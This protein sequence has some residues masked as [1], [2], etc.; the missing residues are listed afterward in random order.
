MSKTS[1]DSPTLVLFE[2][3]YIS[4]SAVDSVRPDHTMSSRLFCLCD[5]GPR[6]AKQRYMFLSVIADCL[7]QNDVTE[8]ITRQ[9]FGSQDSLRTKEEEKRLG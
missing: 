6:C 8:L 2:A 4:M 9:I 1:S 5:T 3:N 7:S